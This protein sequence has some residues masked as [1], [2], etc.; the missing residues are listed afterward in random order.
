M[1]LV[2]P[3]PPWSREKLL[4][5]IDG[6]VKRISRP[7]LFM[8][9]GGESWDIF[10]WGTSCSRIM[11]KVFLSFGKIA[12]ALVVLI[13][14]SKRHVG[15]EVSGLE[16]FASMLPSSK[17]QFFQHLREFVNFNDYY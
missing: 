17:I 15:G 6:S 13:N 12:Q 7:G 9:L 8:S 1:T 3:T 14:L 5:R 4:G 11:R 2:T 16:N 10:S